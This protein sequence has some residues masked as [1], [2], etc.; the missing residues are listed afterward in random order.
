MR[1]AG[2]KAERLGKD[3]T[4]QR[5]C[6]APWHGQSV[7]NR[8]SLGPARAVVEITRDSDQSD[9]GKARDVCW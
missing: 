5:L 2:V 9:S 3:S 7:D 1:L 8:I 6:C 4:S